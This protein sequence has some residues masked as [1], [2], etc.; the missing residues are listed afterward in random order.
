MTEQRIDPTL[1]SPTLDTDRFCELVPT[2]SELRTYLPLAVK[3]L[4]DR[5]RL[6]EY[7][8]PGSACF[9]IF[10]AGDDVTIA[11]GEAAVIGTGLA[12]EIP[13]GHVM[14]VYS[15]SGHG[16]KQGLRLANTTGIIDSDYRGELMV[17]L[18]NDSSAPQT[19]PGQSRCA[20]A[21]VIPVHHVAFKVADELSHTQRGTGGFGSTGT[22]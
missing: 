20:Q 14:L 11:P 7:A 16:F 13:D 17:K 9:D 1:D 21:M 18:H 6:P 15:R 8:T 12:F 4:N 10:G 3:L 2:A 22:A 19:I 5:A